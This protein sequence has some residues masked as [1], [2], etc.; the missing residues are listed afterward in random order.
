[1]NRV[2]PDPPPTLGALSHRPDGLH[3]CVATSQ[4][5]R[6]VSTL[7]THPESKMVGITVMRNASAGDP[8]LSGPGG[9][10]PV[11]EY[12]WS[13]PALPRAPALLTHYERC[14]TGAEMATFT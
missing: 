13:A 4:F 12:P 11:P 10:P 6:P 7:T 8:A 1:M 5:T 9:D 14:R 2:T 3:N